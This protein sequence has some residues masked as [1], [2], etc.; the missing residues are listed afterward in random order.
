MTDQDDF[1]LRLDAIQTSLH[2]TPEGHDRSL[3]GTVYYNNSDRKIYK[4]AKQ[5]VDDADVIYQ[6]LKT[7]KPT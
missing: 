3:G 2:V 6:Y 4:T 5:L 1:K 7:G